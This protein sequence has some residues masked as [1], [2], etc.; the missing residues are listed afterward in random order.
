M[1]VV[2]LWNEDEN[3]N[4]DKCAQHGVT[5][6][7]WEFAFEHYMTDG[8]SDSTGRSIRIGESPDGRLLFLVFEWIEPD[9]M[10]LPITG[11]E[12]KGAI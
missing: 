6:D 5:P 2:C 3:E 1:S 8:L 10:V 4:I 9:W 12:I 7:E 11:Y